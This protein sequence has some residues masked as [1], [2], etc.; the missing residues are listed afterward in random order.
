MTLEKDDI[1][2]NTDR[3]EMMGRDLP[4]TDYRLPQNDNFMA[5]FLRNA[6]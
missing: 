2:G 4:W 3:L 1:D 6:F 5:G